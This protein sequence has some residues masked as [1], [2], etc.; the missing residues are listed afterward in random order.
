L[1]LYSPF[2]NTV[3][4]HNGLGEPSTLVISAEGNQ[5][6]DSIRMTFPNEMLANQNLSPGYPKSINSKVGNKMYHYFLDFNSSLV[7]TI[8]VKSVPVCLST[9][10]SDILLK[11][12]GFWDYSQPKLPTYIPS[13]FS[14]IC[15]HLFELTDYTGHVI[16]EKIYAN[17][18]APPLKTDLQGTFYGPDVA[19]GYI[20]F[21]V[22]N[23]PDSN[24][25]STAARELQFI[26]AHDTTARNVT[27]VN[28]NEAATIEYEQATVS[29]MR[30]HTLYAQYYIQGPVPITELERIAKNM[31]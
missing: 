29:T 26:R 16:F 22:N 31:K 28:G 14:D 7:G 5:S 23:E 24:Y 27:L 19:A 9:N 1:V 18:A 8:I 3:I 13:G 15:D 30:I 12:T 17:K 10:Q 4:W 21:S 6:G 20:T 2:T 11:Q 25:T